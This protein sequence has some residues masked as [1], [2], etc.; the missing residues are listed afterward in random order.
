MKKSTKLISL[1]LAVLMVVTLL[2]TMAL[3]D[4]AEASDDDSI[5]G[6]VIDVINGIQIPDYLVYCSLAGRMPASGAQI[7]MNNQL[8]ESATFTANSLG[9]ALIPKGLLGVYSVSATCNGP[10]S[11]LKYSTIAGINWTIS[12]KPAVEKL[13]LYPV[14][15]LGLNYTDHFSYMIGYPEGTVR[16]EATITRAE[17]ATIIVRLMTEDTR[18]KFYSRTNS[19]SDVNEGDWCNVA[20]STLANARIIKGHDDGT[21]KPDSPITRAEFAAMIGRMFSVEYTSGITPIFGDINGNWAQRYIE[22]LQKLGIVK[23]DENGNFNP[24]D[25]LSRAE[26]AAMCNRLLGRSPDEKSV[27]GC[28]GNITYFSDCSASEWYYADIL[29]ATNSHEYTWSVNLKNV[30]DGGQAVISEAWTNIRTDTPDW[31]ALQK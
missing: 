4:G 26:A 17:V 29:E 12:A 21:F 3:A 6:D 20:V 24:E 15:N 28:S 22:L 10:I 30:I 13:V 11:G 8:G 27:V 19:F 25:N 5:I 16:P 31:G 1:L 18:A 14:L 9:L 7:T 23:G 2:P